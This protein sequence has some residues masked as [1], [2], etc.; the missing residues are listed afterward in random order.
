MRPP[1]LSC[2]QTWTPSIIQS[3]CEPWHLP[4]PESRDCALV[5]RQMQADCC[6]TEVL[7]VFIFFCPTLTSTLWIIPWHLTYPKALTFGGAFAGFPKIR[8]FHVIVVNT[9]DFWWRDI[10]AIGLLES[11]GEHLGFL[12]EILKN[13]VQLIVTLHGLISNL[14]IYDISE[15]HSY[16]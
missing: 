12:K 8:L 7:W 9:V 2:W 10:K 4:S 6:M 11:W 5:W 15:L 3:Q 1:W 16:I 14:L 13:S